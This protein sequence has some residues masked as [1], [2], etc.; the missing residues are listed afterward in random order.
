MIA[1]RVKNDLTFAKPFSICLWFIE[2]GIVIASDSEKGSRSSHYAKSNNG[3]DISLFALLRIMFYLDSFV[4][5]DKMFL[6][7]AIF[8]FFLLN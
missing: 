4:Y 2:K 7:W 6:F 1:T 5:E 8:H 3:I